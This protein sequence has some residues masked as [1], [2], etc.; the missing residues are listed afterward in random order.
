MKLHLPTLCALC[1]LL[2]LS[3]S[4]S[5]HA[6]SFT[7]AVVGR[8]IDSQ[9]GAIPG[10]E[11]TLQS[12]ERGFER[13]TQS[14]E[15]GDYAFELVPPGKFTLRAQAAGFA[16]VSALVEVVV[17]TPVRADLSLGVDS[18]QQNVSVVGESGVS[19]Q[20]ENA[21]L[22]QVIGPREMS[23]LPSVTR[24][25]YDFIALMAGAVRSNDQIGVGFAI[26]GGR[27]QSGNYLLDGAENNEPFMSTVALDVPL[28]SIQ[29]FNVQTNHYSAEY[30]RNSGFTANVVTKGGTEAF[31]GSLYDYVRSSALAANTFE[32]RTEL[33]R[34]DFIRHQFGGTLGGPLRR[35]KL[36]FFASVEPILVRSN[37]ATT[38]FVPTPALVAISAPGT[39]AIF[40]HYPIP[41][42]LSSTA[43]HTYSLCPFGAS[44]D[45]STKAGFVTLPAFALTSRTGPLDA[46]AGFPQNTT[47]AVGRLDWML[48]SNAQAFVRYGY[49]YKYEFA[50]VTQPYSSKLD[51]PQDARNQNVTF[52]LIRTWS[53]HFTTESRIVYSRVLG[54]PDRFTGSSPN[55][56][57]FPNLSI[58]SESAILPFGGGVFDGP[59]NLYQFVQTATWTFRRH[60][61][62]I[63]G[64]FEHLRE[65]RSFGIGQ[66]ADAAFADA[67]GFVD[68]I[69]DLFDIALDPHGHF[70]GEFIDPP[71]GPPS[72]TR[73]FRYNEPALFVED[74]WKIG[75]RLTL[76]P[77][78]RWEYFGVYHSPGAE[79]ALDANFYPASGATALE[80]IAHGRMLRTIDAPGDLRGRF[81][82][83][84]YNNFAP[85][86]GIAWDVLGDGK[87]VLRAGAGIFY[88][89]H[90]GWEFFRSLVNPPSYSLALLR[91]IPITPAMLD[92][93]YSAFPNAPLQLSTSLTQDPA[94]DMRTAY[95][96][97]WNFTLEH[98][99][100][101]TVVGRA[102]YLG[103]SGSRLYSVN[104]VN[105]AG[106]GGLLE[107][108][109]VVPRL[110]AE[111]AVLGPDYTGCGRLN[112]S[113]TNVGLR[114][115]DG[116]SSFHALQLSLESRRA[117][118]WGPEFGVNYT[119]SHSIDDRS[120]SGVST[121][122]GITGGGSLDAFDPRL[123]RGPSDFDARHRVASH[124]IWELPAGGSSNAAAR[125]IFAGWE[126]SGYASYQSGEPFSI[127]DIGTPDH[128]GERTQPRLTGPAPLPSSLVA[129]AATPNS[130]LYLPLN[131][132]YD[133]L[134]GQC[135]AQAAPFGCEISVNGPFTGTLP[136]NF[137][138]QPGLFFLDAAVIKSFPPLRDEMRF[139]LRAEFY[140][141]FNHP[142]LYLNPASLDVSSD[143]FTDSAGS[144]VPGVT[145]S[146]HDNRQIVLAVKF[147][148]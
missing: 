71:F 31:H 10:A 47:L 86:L 141:F 25:P 139:Q 22:G 95:T 132:V 1:L 49:E 140:N 67:Q 131:E 24:S 97:S 8:L 126:I 80:R 27:T 133:P 75:S 144:F 52:N 14:N 138:R 108:S 68:G 101:G 147:L 5:L 79:H 109:C 121:A 4:L 44:C 116:H 119:W 77:G 66:I 15:Q 36:F 110:S 18:L 13:H 12:V 19:V 46:G 127:A 9:G 43:V 62:G 123:D 143:S 2:I 34:P 28:D 16:P 42:N 113:L 85:R 115:N 40:E 21:N 59:E 105:R 35:S 112:S 51:F 87:T 96:S 135:R 11:V 63:G 57:P 136:R 102:S 55:V 81:Y 88:D 78:L 90:V 104:N 73:H 58:E 17:A 128:T 98:E 6:Q 125:G 142:N 50:P 146:F 111:G 65:N 61:L 130:Y 145:A 148:F 72:F 23:E 124:F 118:R 53:A 92:D 93:Q 7:G 84:D 38:F 82:R 74:T 94:T 60:T 134:S 48:N 122:L 29:E 3:A 32:N 20:T 129:D 89:R 91:N 100:L 70:P 39:Q 99:F 120:V 37:G 103:S 117:W 64:H 30:G 137:F 33:P 54:D 106:S 114:A 83:P 41:V 45:P 76:T 107:P 69:L 26:N 56:V